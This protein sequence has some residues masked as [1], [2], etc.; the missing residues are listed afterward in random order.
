MSKTARPVA[1]QTVIVGVI[2]GMRGGRHTK[3]SG[4]FAA[5]PS[6][7]MQQRR[8]FTLIGIDSDAAGTKPY[9]ARLVCAVHEGG[10]LVVWGDPENME[11]VEALREATFPCA[12]LCL[13]STPAEVSHV[14][15]ALAWVH[16]DDYLLIV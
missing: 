5:P 12:V 3:S 15:E 10:K 8:H 9:P 6:G 2:D 4:L 14:P 7:D 11:N 16:P 13:A 1:A